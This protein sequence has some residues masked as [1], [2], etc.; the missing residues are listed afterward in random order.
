[1]VER[2]PTASRRMA[3]PTGAGNYSSASLTPKEVFGILRR[4]IFLIF[5]LTILGLGVGGGT[6]YFLY[7]YHP[8]YSAKTF[9][10][11]L[12]PVEKDPMTIGTVQL[13]DV[14]KPIIP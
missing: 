6:W 14:M 12:S 4:H 9:I 2:I 7:K 10:Q 13:Q 1:M 11:V 3:R 8:R 5:F